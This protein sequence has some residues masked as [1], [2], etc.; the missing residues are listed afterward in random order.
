VVLRQVSPPREP[1]ANQ[2]VLWG[3]L[4]PSPEPRPLVQLVLLR[5]RRAQLVS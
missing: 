1:Q 5:A 2:L 3:R 4:A